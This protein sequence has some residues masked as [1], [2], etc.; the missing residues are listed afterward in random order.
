MKDAPIAPKRTRFRRHAPAAVEDPRG[1]VPYPPYDLR[2]TAEAASAQEQAR[3]IAENTRDSGWEPTTPEGRT[4]LVY[5]DEKGDEWEEEYSLEDLR[6]L[7]EFAEERGINRPSSFPGAPDRSPLTA[8]NLEAQAWSNGSDARIPKPLNATWPSNDNVL[9]RQ[10]LL[11]SSIGGCTAALVG[12]RLVLTAAHCVVNANGQVPNGTLYMARAD[13]G[14]NPWGVQG[15]SGSWRDAEYV[16]NNCHLTYN[17]ATRETCGK[18]DWALLRLNSNSWN[19]GDPNATAGSMGFWVAPEG[20]WYARIDGYPGC[21]YAD[22]PSGCVA[23]RAYGQDI[24]HS[25]FNFRGLVGGEKTIFQSANDTSPG[26]SG[27]PIWS[28]SYPDSNGPYV[29][30]IVT[31]SMCATCAAPETPT[32]NDKTYPTMN[33]KMTAAV[34]GIITDKIALYP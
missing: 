21:A 17:T 14:T 34:A 22:A 18:Y 20:G 7:R 25:L 1:G 2:G 26:H 12:R 32:A 5:E 11:S 10:G 19:N 4:R 23:G 29:L 31:N 13:A 30:G 8:P 16:N 6:R 15:A 33:W 24:G 3:I 9:S 28:S 27:G